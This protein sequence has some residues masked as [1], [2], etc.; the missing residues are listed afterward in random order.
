[1]SALAVL[2][3]ASRTL[4]SARRGLRVIDADSLDTF[5][6]T[7]EFSRQHLHD[8][9]ALAE[10]VALDVPQYISHYGG[11][12]GFV[13]GANYGDGMTVLSPNFKK[14]TVVCP[15][16][17]AGNQIKFG[18]GAAEEKY[19][20]GE[21]WEF[22]VQRV[23]VKVITEIQKQNPQSFPLVLTRDDTTCPI[24]MID[25][26]GA[27]VACHNK[28]QICLPCFNLLPKFSGVKKCPL[29]NTP[30]Y[31]GQELEKVEKMNGK[32]VDKDSYYY[33]DLNSRA[34]SHTD[35]CYN[36]ALFL[37]LIKFYAGVGNMEKQRTMLMSSFY[38]FYMNHKDHFGLYTFAA[39]YQTNGNDRI[40]KPNGGELPEAF[41][42]YILALRNR[43]FYKKIY[44]DVAHTEIYLHDYDERDFYKQLRELDG[45]IERVEDYVGHRKPILQRE[46]Y[47]RYYVLK[48][49]NEQIEAEFKDILFRTALNAISFKHLFE[50]ERKI[51][52]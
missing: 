15:S 22:C 40:L 32:E 6:E 25:L 31:T 45:N 3:P 46:I 1:M 38:N 7:D 42:Q 39:M 51:I 27:V 20:R 24:C 14:L 37:H 35:F 4:F 28:H 50:T 21:C 52:A 16:R 41:Q 19:T 34:N 47:F 10:F 11:L 9:P 18:H 12:P 5:R 49:T 44:D 17:V 8:N 48:H 29:C 43:H 2:P 13:L 30:T 26:S 36:E 23:R 33:I